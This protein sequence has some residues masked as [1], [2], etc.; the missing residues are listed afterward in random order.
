NTPLGAPVVDGAPPSVA[1]AA[2]SAGVTVSSFVDVT[3]DASDDV[4]VAG[5]TFYMDGAPIGV[6]G[7]SAP[8]GGTWSTLSVENGSHTLTAVARDTS[9]KTTTSAAVSVEVNN[10]VGSGPA[11]P[12]LVSANGRYLEDQ[13][14]KP[15]RIH[16][17]AAWS[18][19]SNLTESEI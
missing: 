3:A 10:V 17:E 5:V 9:N 18:L 12:V 19:I 11:Y 6:E 2:P 1:I 16:A 7:T 14:G 8:Y 15:F 4:A 13:N